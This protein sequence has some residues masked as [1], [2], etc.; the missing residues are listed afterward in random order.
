MALLSLCVFVFPEV[1]VSSQAPLP[2]AAATLK[3]EAVVER[4]FHSR[5]SALNLISLP[6][7][8]APALCICHMNKIIDIY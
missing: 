5:L 8:R 3:L 7:R 6:I 4:R 2:C 1:R